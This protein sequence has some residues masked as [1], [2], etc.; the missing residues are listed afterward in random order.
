MPIT[1][2]HAHVN[3]AID[4]FSKDS[5]YFGIGKATPWLDD[6]KPPAPEID[7]AVLDG[8]IGLKKVE[9]SHLVVRD[10]V[11]GTIIYRDS[12]WRIVPLDQAIEEGAKWV[13]IESAIL[14]DELPLG[15]YR[16]VG[17]FTG[18]VKKAGVAPGKY[19]L[20]PSDIE[21]VGTLEVID[22]RPPANRLADQKERLSVVIEF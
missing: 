11:N 6:K 21:D 7:V 8:L 4:F 13:Y 15:E 2:T 20:L 14:Y 5:I 17:V 18:T 16:Q 1:T 19:N 3:R 12:R 22:N 9:V 10:D